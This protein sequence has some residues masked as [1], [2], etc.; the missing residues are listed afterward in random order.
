MTRL[1]AMIFIEKQ[2]LHTNILFRPDEIAR[3]LAVM[4]P[5]LI[6]VFPAH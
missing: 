6:N 2:S 1:T 3:D 5:V 4:G